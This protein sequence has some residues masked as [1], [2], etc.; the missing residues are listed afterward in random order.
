M[1]Y[2]DYEVLRDKYYNGHELTSDQIKGRIACDIEVSLKYDYEIIKKILE[3]KNTGSHWGPP[4]KK[5][6]FS[7]LKYYQPYF[8]NTEYPEYPVE[9][10]S[11]SMGF[12]VSKKV[13]TL[14]VWG[15]NR[16]FL[17]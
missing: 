15:E 11:I 14:Q 17:L 9:K 12:L 7:R 4:G 16:V 2:W 10:N 1:R 5:L 6:E 8:Q 13:T 3:K